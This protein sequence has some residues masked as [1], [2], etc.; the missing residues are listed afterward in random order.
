LKTGCN[1]AESSEE[2]YGFKKCSFASGDDDDD[3]DENLL[4]N[5]RLARWLHYVS[6]VG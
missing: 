5:E 3:D 6:P 2:G 1:L 4:T